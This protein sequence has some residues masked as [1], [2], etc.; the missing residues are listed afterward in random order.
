LAVGVADKLDTVAGIFEIGEKPTGAK[1]P[2]G[3]RRAAIGLLRILIEKRLDLDL[4]RLIK[5]ALENVRAD[6]AKV[7]S[8]KAAASGKGGESASAGK[9][10]GVPGAKSSAAP[11]ADT[12]EQ[13]YDFIMERLRA[14]Y[15]ERSASPVPGT[16]PALTTE[17]FDAVLATKPASPLDFAARLNALRAF[18]DLPEATALAAA[19]KRIANIL[20]KAGELQRNT[21]EVEALKDPAEVR[22]FD[23][24]RS[25]QDSVA[26]AVA[27]REYANALGRLA[28]LRPPVDAFFEQV[29][30]MDEDPK[31]RSN[32]L[33]LLAQLHGLFVGIADLSRLPG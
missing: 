10:S 9:A 23:A 13:V 11:A 8:A 21:V 19:N 6:I 17:M 28:Q 26:T 18:V 27:Q 4:R 33:A 30:V 22:L 14:Y 32:R 25:L 20:R 2:F 31:L 5:L 24:M 1:D 12:A 16:G 7:L 29:M 15:L 3:L